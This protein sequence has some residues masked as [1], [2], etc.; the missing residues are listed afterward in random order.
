[1]YLVRIKILVDNTVMLA[2]TFVLIVYVSSLFS[3]IF[4]GSFSTET[5]C[6]VLYEHNVYTIEKGAINVRAFQVL[7]K[8]RR[9]NKHS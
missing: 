7:R 6:A 2:Y 1:M 3:S 5:Q 4:P 9:G 8:L